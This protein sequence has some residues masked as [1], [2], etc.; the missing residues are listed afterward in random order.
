MGLRLDILPNGY[1]K[2]MILK[3]SGKTEAY[4]IELFTTNNIMFRG[5]LTLK[6]SMFTVKSILGLFHQLDKHLLL[7]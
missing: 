7:V 6:N 5:I 1:N 3:S 4:Q 2:K